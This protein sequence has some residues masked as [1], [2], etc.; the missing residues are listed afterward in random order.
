MFNKWMM[1]TNLGIMSGVWA[2]LICMYIG[3]L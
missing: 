2:T 3:V 1:F